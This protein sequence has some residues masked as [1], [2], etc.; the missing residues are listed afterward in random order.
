M[1]EEGAQLALLASF[2]VSYI[3]PIQ[4]NPIELSSQ[5]RI[6]Q[7][8]DVVGAMTADTGSKLA[9]LRVDGGVALSNELLQYQVS[10]A[11]V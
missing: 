11:L 3:P 2:V 4:F 10:C 5:R 8:T 6:G 1:V 9:A 7:A